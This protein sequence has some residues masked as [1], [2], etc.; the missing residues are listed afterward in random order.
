MEH[1]EYL[2]VYGTLLPSLCRNQLLRGCCSLGPAM[3]QGTLV[4]L[5]MF[6]G[7]LSGDG[8]VTGWVVKA[9]QELIRTLDHVEGFDSDSPQNSLYLRRKIGARMLSDG[10]TRE[11]WTYVYN[12]AGED[13]RIV[14]GDYRR[15]LLEKKAAAG[16]G[17][18]LLSYGS[19]ISTARLCER[20][21]DVREAWP[22]RIQDFRLVFNKA[23]SSNHCTYAN[24]QYTGDGA[25]V[26]CAVQKVTLEQIEELDRFEG[27][28]N[29]YIRTVGDAILEKGNKKVS[30]FFYLAHPDHLVEGMAPE[31][32][33]LQHIQNGYAE[34]GKTFD[35]P[36]REK[37]A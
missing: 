34:Y 1:P 36:D 37:S 13:F 18:Y 35:L 29:Q 27:V 9:D 33:Y 21:G 26:F 17:V 14:C 4:D 23:A 20:L 25:A 10:S 24:L 7:L 6:P 28:P 3:V 19:N 32:D 12:H 15:H 31:A 8:P 2:F 5:G 16:D 22:A 30:G 11:C